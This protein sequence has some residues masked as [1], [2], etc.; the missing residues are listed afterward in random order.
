VSVDIAH[1]TSGERRRAAPSPTLA[2]A[3]AVWDGSR[4][5]GAAV[6]PGLWEALRR[7]VER[8][9]SEWEKVV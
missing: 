4:P 2:N 7:A 6:A 5:L 8:V 9:G 1:P 3:D